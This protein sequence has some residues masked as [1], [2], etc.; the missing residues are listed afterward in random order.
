MEVLVEVTS[1]THEDHQHHS[2]QDKSKYLPG[3]QPEGASVCHL[4]FLC[5]LQPLHKF[6]HLLEE[7]ALPLGDVGFSVPLEDG[8]LAQHV[9]CG[10]GRQSE[11]VP[12]KYFKCLSHLHRREVI[13]PTGQVEFIL[14]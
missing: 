3:R 10:E 11:K 9:R 1:C 6:F 7:N 2:C 5:V 8:L 14:S 12:L 4:T 13:K